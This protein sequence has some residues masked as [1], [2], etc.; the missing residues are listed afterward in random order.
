MHG[1]AVFATVPLDRQE[2]LASAYSLSLALSLYSLGPY[3]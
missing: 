1:V 2:T 3:P